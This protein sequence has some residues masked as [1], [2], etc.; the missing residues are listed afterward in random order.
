MRLLLAVFTVVMLSGCG[1]TRVLSQSDTSI[2]ID[3]NPAGRG[4]AFR[5]AEQ[6]C[7]A[8]NKVP[9]YASGVPQRGITTSTWR[10]E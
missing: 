1:I 4:E 5:V 10:C 3:H 2:T 9:F 7:R 6:H 8:R